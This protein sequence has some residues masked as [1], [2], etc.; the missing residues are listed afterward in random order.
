MLCEPTNPLSDRADKEDMACAKQN[1]EAPDS[2]QPRTP[3]PRPDDV[4]RDFEHL[5]SPMFR[6]VGLIGEIPLSDDEGVR[7]ESAFRELLHVSGPGKATQFLQE[8]AP[9]TLVC[10]LVWKGIRGYQE[11]DYWAEVCQSVDLPRANW[12][13]KWGEI[14]EAVLRYFK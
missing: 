1:L 14:F 9:C 10:F 4:L 3:R 13:Q 7:I 11:G 12:P 5:F 6:E 2:L 8:E